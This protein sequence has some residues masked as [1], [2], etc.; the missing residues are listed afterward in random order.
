MASLN[1]L[2]LWV[3]V[4]SEDKMWVQSEL[5]AKAEQSGCEKQALQQAF[6]F[7]APVVIVY[8][9]KRLVSNIALG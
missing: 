2:E 9:T 3:Q 7:R 1:L 8:Q 5:R 4:P 6:Y